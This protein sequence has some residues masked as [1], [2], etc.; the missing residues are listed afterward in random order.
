MPPLYRCYIIESGSAGIVKAVAL[1][2]LAL[3][4]IY[5]KAGVAMPFPAFRYCCTYLFKSDG[6][7]FYVVWYNPMASH[8]AQYIRAIEKFKH[9]IR[10]L[11][12]EAFPA[13]G[14]DMIHEQG[15]VFL[16]QDVKRS[17]FWKD[18]AYKFM[19]FLGGIFLAR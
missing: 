4:L 3:V 18:I 1:K 7:R 9:F 12:T 8:C 13:V 17:S 19:V 16:C 6:V 2:R 14:I 10:A 11:I 5:Q 15:N